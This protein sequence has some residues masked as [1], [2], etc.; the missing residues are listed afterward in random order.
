MAKNHWHTA[1]S[2]TRSEAYKQEKSEIKKTK[3]K[4]KPSN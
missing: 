3:K 1:G 4:K 2:K